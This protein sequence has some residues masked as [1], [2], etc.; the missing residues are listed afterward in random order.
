MNLPLSVVRP[1]GPLQAGVG[2]ALRLSLHL[3]PLYLR[4]PLCAEFSIPM[5][6]MQRW[7]FFVD[8][9]TAFS[10]QASHKTRRRVLRRNVYQPMAFAIPAC[11]R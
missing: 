10:F 7:M 4:N 6:V 5:L 11:M 3:Y 2:G 1:L 8:H 9:L